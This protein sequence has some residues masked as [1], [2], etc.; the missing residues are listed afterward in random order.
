MI[1][2]GP[3]A[4]FIIGSYVGVF[5]VTGALILWVWANSN[6]Q[7][8]RLADLDDRGISRRSEN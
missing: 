3:H 8:N 2:L 5:S 6:K 7:K 4:I 1:D